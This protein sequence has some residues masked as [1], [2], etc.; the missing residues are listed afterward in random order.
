MSNHIIQKERIWG[1]SLSIH[2]TS[3]WRWT[4]CFMSHPL[5]S[6]L[7]PLPPYLGRGHT[8][9]WSVSWFS[10]YQSYAHSCAFGLG[11]V[12]GRKMFFTDLLIADSHIPFVMISVNCLRDRVWN[13]LGDRPPG[14]SIYVF[15]LQACLSGI[16]LLWLIDIW[17]PILTVGSTI[18]QALVQY[19]IKRKS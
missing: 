9:L 2:W 7:D 4:I 16:V 15:I 17:G 14:T 19:C 12:L 8:E 11:V 13:K 10:W 18:P 6:I 1:F 3:L 5:P